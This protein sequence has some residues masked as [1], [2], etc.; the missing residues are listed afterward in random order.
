MNLLI[1]ND[2]NY[3]HTAHVSF[4]RFPPAPLVDRIIK[5]LLHPWVGFAIMPVFALANAGVPIELSVLKSLIAIAV[6]LGLFV[7]KPLGIFVLSWLAVKSGIASLPEGVSWNAM[8]AGGFL[9][10]IGFTMALFI[11]GLAL[12]DPQQLVAAK[13]GILF[14][15]L[16]AAVVG[17]GLMLVFL[18]KPAEDQ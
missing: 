15:S 2:W 13:V 17:A 11:A 16:A 3:Q 18:P 1:W 6:M 5:P 7:G 10:G 12:K 14:G 4:S 8:V 9:A